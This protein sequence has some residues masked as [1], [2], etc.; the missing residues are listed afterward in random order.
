MGIMIRRLNLARQPVRLEDLSQTLLQIWNG[1][2]QEEIRACF[3]RRNQ[4]QEA[5][6]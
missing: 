3:N 1:I 6:E 5:I 4:L 2:P